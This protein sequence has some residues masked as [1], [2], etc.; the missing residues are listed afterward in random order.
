MWLFIKQVETADAGK[1]R[2]E[3]KRPE[4]TGRKG[5]EGN[6]GNRD[7]DDPVMAQNAGYCC[8]TYIQAV[9]P[10]PDRDRIDRH[11]GVSRP[12][13]CTVYRTAWLYKVMDIITVFIF[14]GSSTERHPLPANQKGGIHKDDRKYKHKCP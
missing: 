6:N 4:K 11:N 8:I 1:H 13:S 9:M 2:N 7:A 10:F 3:V 5:V 14:Y 12:D